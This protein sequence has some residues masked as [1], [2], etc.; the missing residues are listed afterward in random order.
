[1]M[2]RGELQRLCSYA[3]T[4]V[5]S[6]TRAVDDTGFAHLSSLPLEEVRISECT[7]VTDTG[8]P[9]LCK[10]PLQIL[11]MDG[12]EKVTQCWSGSSL[13]FVPEGLEHKTHISR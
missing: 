10:L 5:L 1:M 9:H 6:L 8:L 12:C 7:E 4:Q 2:T 11:H 3:N 13:I